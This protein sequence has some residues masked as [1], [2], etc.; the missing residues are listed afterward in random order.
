MSQ[1]E[2]LASNL[3]KLRLGNSNPI[4]SSS[5]YFTSS[6]KK[7]LS[8]IIQETIKTI[9]HPTVVEEREPQI[10]FSSNVEDSERVPDVVKC[11]REFSGKPGE[12]SSWRKSV[13]R[14]F[15]MYEQISNTP[16]YFV[17]LHT[18]RHKIVGEA[19]AALESYRT[20]LN[21]SKIKKCLMLHYSDKRDVGTLEYQMS[22]LVQRGSSVEEFYQQ[23]Y[24]YLSLILDKIDC[25][26]LGE[27]ALVTLTSTYR[28]KALDT[29]IRGLNGALPSL[30]SIREPKSLPEALHMCLKLSNMNYRANHAH[31]MPSGFQNK[32]NSKNRQQQNTGQYQKFSGSR[33]FYP[34]LTHLPQS[35]FQ[36]TNQGPYSNQ[37]Q[38]YYTPQIHSNPPLPLR[39]P[40]PMEI[41]PTIQT[42][43]VNYQ[44]RPVPQ[45]SRNF[46]PREPSNFRQHHNHQ[47]NFQQNKRPHSQNTQQPNKFPK[48][49][50]IE[51]VTEYPP[52]QIVEYTDDKYYQIPEDYQSEY[53][54]KI[55][56]DDTTI[57]DINFL[58]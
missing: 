35:Q 3:S 11:L 43:L 55:D 18:I 9:L 16:K 40:V 44:N 39:P 6:Q 42:R 8:S 49:H 22:T 36:V 31:N 14:I 45:Q 48:V 30:L 23:I 1:E 56:K 2:E 54:G 5:T 4:P 12:F 41:D 7:E 37:R 20:P 17:I 32:T 46:S 47:D 34:E 19:D 13:D 50:N 21:W 53:E 15:Q 51:T 29:F 38:T 26:E 28:D 58:D 25:L 24:Q 10:D 33:P 52:E 27:E 57:D